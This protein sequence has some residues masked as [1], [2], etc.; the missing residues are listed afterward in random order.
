MGRG[1]PITTKSPL[2]ILQTGHQKLIR[3]TTR[4]KAIEESHATKQCTPLKHEVSQMT[5]FGEW[6]CSMRRRVARGRGALDDAARYGKGA[7]CGV[8]WQQ[9]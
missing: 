5:L 7:G 1:R 6:K 3:K 4:G 8:G 9:H 2:K